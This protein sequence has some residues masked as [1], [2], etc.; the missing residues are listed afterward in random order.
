ML[1][2]SIRFRFLL[3]PP[4]FL[5]SLSNIPFRFDFVSFGILLASCI[6]KKMVYV[7]SQTSTLGFR[8]Y[9]R[10][11]IQLINATFD[12]CSPSSLRWIKVLY[13]SVSHLIKKRSIF[14]RISGQTYIG[15]DAHF[16]ITSRDFSTLRQIAIRRSS[17]FSQTELA[18]HDAATHHGHFSAFIL[19]KRAPCS[20]LDR[21][22]I[23]VFIVQHLEP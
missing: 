5:P 7:H 4:F 13:F 9:R 16:V 8:D 3:S 20:R 1:L 23:M 17:T 6:M 11:N 14:G 10:R 22:A 2:D 15:R 18:A 19:D 12:F 21:G